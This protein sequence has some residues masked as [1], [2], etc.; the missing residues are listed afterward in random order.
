MYKK[1]TG[2]RP[3]N[4]SNIT[5]R[6][7]LCHPFL[8]FTNIYFKLMPKEKLRLYSYFALQSI[9]FSINLHLKQFGRKS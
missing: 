2:K 5:I 7:T 3:T 9:A 4:T 1:L 8:I 6:E